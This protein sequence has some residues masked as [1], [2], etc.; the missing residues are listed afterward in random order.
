M[1]GGGS[2]LRLEGQVF[3]ELGASS[4]LVILET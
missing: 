1:Q 4:Y 3:F 2:W